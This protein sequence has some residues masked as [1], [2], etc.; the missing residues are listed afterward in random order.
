[1]GIPKEKGNPEVQV[2]SGPLFP[3]HYVEGRE[4]HVPC[5]KE[6]DGSLGIEW[7]GPALAVERVDYTIGHSGSLFI[8]IESSVNVGCPSLPRQPFLECGH[9][10]DLL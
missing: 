9:G 8:R 6:Y 1:M 7:P 5:W 4:T 2:H 10:I 3:D